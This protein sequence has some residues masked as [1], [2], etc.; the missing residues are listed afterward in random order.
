ML[1]AARLNDVMQRSKR[2]EIT[3]PVSPVV[4]RH[5]ALLLS[6]CA[7]FMT[8]CKH[9]HEATP[10]VAQLRAQCKMPTCSLNPRAAMMR[11]C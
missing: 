9:A 8:A 7:D 6:V 5:D 3:Q 2:A 10:E 4:T 11:R 1:G